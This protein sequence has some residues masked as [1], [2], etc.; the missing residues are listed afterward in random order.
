VAG[1][2]VGALYH[3]H[4]TII[5]KIL[6]QEFGFL[7]PDKRTDILYRNVGKKLPLLY[8]IAQKGAVLKKN[9]IRL[10]SDIGG[11]CSQ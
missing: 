7:N 8:R 10:V 9:V 1:N 11:S 3:K 4:Y 2:I 5:I 6:I